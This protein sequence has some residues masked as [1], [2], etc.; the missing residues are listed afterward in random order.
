[1]GGAGPGGHSSL[2]E[3]VKLLKKKEFS[4]RDRIQKLEKALEVAKEVLE[5]Y[6]SHRA[7][8]AVKKIDEALK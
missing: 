7:I 5:K 2:H 6:P 3:L 4:Y 8:D 1:M